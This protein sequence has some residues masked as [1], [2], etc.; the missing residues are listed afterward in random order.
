MKGAGADIAEEMDLGYKNMKDSHYYT[1]TILLFLF[2][3]GLAIAIPDV[4]IVFNFVSAIAVSCLG[5]LF[6][7]VFFLAAE[8]KF[9]VEPEVLQKN[10]YHRVMAWVHM[11]LGI[12]IF[13]L[14]FTQSILSIIN[15]TTNPEEA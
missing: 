13:L 6:P 15:P 10:K 14:C 12:I 11:A 1:A 5:F 4:E 9:N 8:R 3:A 7:A 2:E